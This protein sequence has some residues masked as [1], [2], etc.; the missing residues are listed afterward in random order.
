M[1]RPDRD[2]ASIALT[3]V[4]LD[5]GSVSIESTPVGAVFAGKLGA[6]GKSLTGSWTEKAVT[7]PVVFALAT[8]ETAWM[9]PTAGMMAATADPAFEVASI[10]PSSSEES[11]RSFGLRA[12]RF[13]AKFCTVDDLMKFAYGVRDR[14]IE[15]APGWMDEEHY[16]I[17]AEADTPG[18]PSK[19]QDWLMLR[20]L[21]AERFGL[22]VH[23]IHKDFAVYALQGGGRPPKYNVSDA[24]P[25]DEFRIFV[26]PAADGET[27]EMF[28]DISIAEFDDVLMNFIRDRQIVDETGLKAR[29]DFA[30]HVPQEVL[31]SDDQNA[32]ANAMIEGVKGIGMKLVAKHAPLEVLVIDRV[33]KP[34]PN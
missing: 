17:V 24:G 15:G 7:L 27:A 26:Q 4:K 20:K 1:Y 33:E 8:P 13:T 3:K 6:D 9:H 14:Q 10:R 34:S 30:L 12:H 18:R 16:D 22:K 2:P 29:Y 23:V 32:R 11:Q 5:A 21:L 31:H 28:T 25:D 19:E